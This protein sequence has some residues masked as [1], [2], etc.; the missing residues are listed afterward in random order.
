VLDTVVDD[1]GLDGDGWIQLTK[2][3]RRQEPSS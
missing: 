3:V 2:R 1:Y